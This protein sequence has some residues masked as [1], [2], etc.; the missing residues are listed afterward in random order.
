MDLPSWCIDF[1]SWLRELV[2]KRMKSNLGK[3]DFCL[4]EACLAPTEIDFSSFTP[5]GNGP[6]VPA[7]S[8]GALRNAAR[9]DGL[10]PSFWTSGVPEYA[11]GMSKST[12][13]S[14]E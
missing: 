3:T 5:S 13:M 10:M 8:S 9:H 6:S 1:S 2:K 12:V 4:G 11:A 7:K 14:F